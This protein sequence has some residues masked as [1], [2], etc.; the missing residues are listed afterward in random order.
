MTSDEGLLTNKM[1]E[2]IH[3]EISID[4]G[5]D[6][7]DEDEDDEESGVVFKVTT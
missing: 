3:Q 5:I 2:K 7:D 1:A 4:S 6:H